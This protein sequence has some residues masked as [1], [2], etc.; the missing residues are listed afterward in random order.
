MGDS[1][2][3]GDFSSVTELGTAIPAKGRRCR[4]TLPRMVGKI[5][6]FLEASVPQLPGFVGT[7]LN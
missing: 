3:W 1:P 5:P 7:H 2:L 4:G 6:D